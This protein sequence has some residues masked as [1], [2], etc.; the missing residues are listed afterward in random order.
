MFSLRIIR[1]VLP[2]IA[3]SVSSLVLAEQ[4]PSQ[5]SLT[6]ENRAPEDSVEIIKS[7]NDKRDY[8]S[9]TLANGLR[10]LLVSDPDT[11]KS[12]ASIDVNVGSGHDPESI[13]GLAHFLEHMLFLGTEKYPEAD[14]YHSFISTYGGTHNAYTSA[15]HTNYFFEVNNDHFDG[16]LDRFSQFFVS[17]LLDEDYTRREMN[18]VH[19]EYQSKIKSD[20]RRQMD[21][22]RQLVNPLHPSAN[23]SVGSLE[24]L[25]AGE[26]AQLKKALRDFYKTYYFSQNM[27]LVLYSS[28]S[29]KAL[30]VAAKEY[31]SQIPKGQFLEELDEL[32]L[33]GE[34]ELPLTVHVQS[35]KDEYSFSMMFP[36]PSAEV[37][38]SEKPLQ[39]IGN[40]LGHEGKGSLFSFLN[41]AGWVERL[42]AGQ[43]ISGKDQGAF[44]VT[45]NLTPEGRKNYQ[46]IASF[47]FV[48]IEKIKNDGVEQWRYD[49]QSKLGEIA[50]EYS[51]RQNP[52]S[53][54]SWLSNVMH[55][56]PAA[57]VLRGSYTYDA[58]DAG[59]IRRYL[60]AMNPDNVVY[61]LRSADELVNAKTYYY[62]VDYRVDRSE[63][64]LAK[65]TRKQVKNLTLPAPNPFIPDKLS[66]IGIEETASGLPVKLFSE[67]NVEFWYKADHDFR[68]PKAN[69]SVRV[70]SPWLG[71]SAKKAATAHLYAMLLEDQLNEYE[72]PANLAG[73]SFDL[74]ANGRGFDIDVKGYSSKQADLYRQIMMVVKSS[75]FEKKRFSLLKEKLL[76]DWKNSA[77]AT[78]YHQLFDAAPSLL[79]SPYWDKQALAKALDSVEFE[80]IKMISR[81]V[82]KGAHFKGLAYGNLT[83]AQAREFVTLSKGVVIDATAESEIPAAKVTK[84]GQESQEAWFYSVDHSDVAVALYLQA[85]NDSAE[86]RAQIALLRQILKSSFYYHLRTEQQLGYIVF[87]TSMPLRKVSSLILLVQ[88]PSHSYENVVQSIS[89]FVRENA[90]QSELFDQH[91]E[92]VIA[93]LAKQPKNLGEQNARYWGAILQGDDTYSDRA[94]LIDA[95]EGL[96]EDD[97]KDFSAEFLSENRGFWFIAGAGNREESPILDGVT[98]IDGE[99]ASVK[100]GREVFVYP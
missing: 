60:N 34:E 88:S 64:D 22:L 13:P 38:V 77:Q 95:L 8:Q 28:Q 91:R 49:E 27:T 54:V 58:F 75:K 40:L 56:Y 99:P 90:G 76:R 51:E 25:S 32:A 83:E 23:F 97:F 4:S 41:E 15:D 35:L 36:V 63:I 70:L 79:Y 87:A 5:Q 17:P 42:S 19:S 71:Q 50:F 29:L 68:V 69:L 72:Y 80:D 20:Y 21:V 47:V 43:I 73:L 86:E 53:T 100:Q 84:L 12:A 62:D 1:V 37:Y 3:L 33:F 11:E 2:V 7:P 52:S 48:M 18:A 26:P 46:Q 16:A 44:S 82:W 30:E 45:M 10:V 14:D 96:S 31:F 55:R 39:Y 74:R 9:L 24:T 98:W 65:V 81:E 78:T 89:T 67:P 93:E 57:D 94:V 61:L 66:L 6:I 92:A 85:R 59:L